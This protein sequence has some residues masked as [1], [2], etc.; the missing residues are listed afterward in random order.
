MN[1]VDER[2]QTPNKQPLTDV[3]VRMTRKNSDYSKLVNP[4]TGISPFGEAK[5]KSKQQT[6]NE[7]YGKTNDDE[8]D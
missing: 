8:T 5:K 7:F 2:K 3:S 4:D 6:L 1:L